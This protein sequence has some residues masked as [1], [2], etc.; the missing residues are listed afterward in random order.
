MRW[1]I[2]KRY[3][4]YAYM[5]A[6]SMLSQP[7]WNGNVILTNPDIREKASGGSLA[8]YLES[9]EADR[10]SECIGLFSPVDEAPRYFRECDFS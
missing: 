10:F 9:G 5:P 4:A 3:V 1:G 2:P 8:G 6:N 7:S